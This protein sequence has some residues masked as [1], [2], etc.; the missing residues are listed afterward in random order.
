MF[1]NRYHLI[2]S[3]KLIRGNL[4]NN[5]LIRGNSGKNTIKWGNSAIN[6]DICGVIFGYTVY[7]H[8][9]YLIYYINVH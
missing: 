4:G 9:V 7:A 2:L 3:E 1:K 6:F 8:F 5:S